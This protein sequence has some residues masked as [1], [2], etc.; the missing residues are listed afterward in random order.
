VIDLLNGNAPDRQPVLTNTC[1][2][3]VSDKDV[4]HVASVHAYD[5]EKKT[6]MAVPGAGGLSPSATELEGVYAMDW[7]RNIWA[8]SLS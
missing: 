8:D 3:F 1:Y 4:I 7:A 2:S 6:M 5:A